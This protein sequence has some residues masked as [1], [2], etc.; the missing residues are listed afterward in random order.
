[1][2]FRNNI[3][4]CVIVLT[5]CASNVYAE[6]GSF[7]VPTSSK[8]YR[9]LYQLV[10]LKYVEPESLNQ[11]PY[12]MKRFVDAVGNAKKKIEKNSTVDVTKMDYKKYDK[13]MSKQLTAG[14]L[15]SAIENECIVDTGGY[16]IN[17]L[18]KMKLEGQ[19]SKGSELTIIPDNGVGSI[20]AKTVPLL[21]YQ[22]GEGEVDGF[23][24]AAELEV[25][26][27]ISKHFSFLAQPILFAQNPRNDD[28]YAG[29]HMR[30]GYGIMSFGNF[31]LEVGRDELVIG[32]GEYG[33][34]LYT[35]NARGFD[36]IR[37]SNPK[38]A[39]LPW[40]FK[41][42]GKW[43]VTMFGANMG[44]K[45]NFKYAWLGGYA[46]TL[47]PVKWVELGFNHGVIM[48]G[49]GAPNL[50]A[51]DVIGE[52]FGFRPSGSSSDSP[53]PANQLMEASLLIRI[54]W[55][56]TEF[57]SVLTNEDKRDSVKAIF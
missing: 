42:L 52:Y 55:K 22:G 50:S 13:F 6:S 33:G 18:H 14:R 44:P 29:V 39:R 37:I 30:Y 11:R 47:M 43:Q 31:A 45:Y 17:A 8:C 3:L 51:L 34:L 35:G 23:Y 5:L 12:S 56:M 1:M 26:G 57:Y 53:N 32:P 28:A 16:W 41:Y 2:N 20:N 9:Y 21:N 19:Y 48:G 38:P 40:Y 25:R 15:I 49:N 36:N 54:P 7:N 24:G 4:L 27:Q 46:V 10:G